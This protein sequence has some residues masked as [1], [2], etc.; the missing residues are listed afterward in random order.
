MCDYTS[1]CLVSLSWFASIFFSVRCIFSSLSSFTD[2]F[3]SVST[4]ELKSSV[5]VIPKMLTMI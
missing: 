4:R 5:N 2:M 1:R 3:V